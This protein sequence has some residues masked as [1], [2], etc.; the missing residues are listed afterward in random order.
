MGKILHLLYR[1]P[2]C[3]YKTPRRCGFSDFHILLWAASANNHG[4]PMAVLQFEDEVLLKKN[5]DM[6][7]ES[8]KRVMKHAKKIKFNRPFRTIET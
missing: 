1:P 5:G 2:R 8:V 6:L 7:L 3:L 4:L